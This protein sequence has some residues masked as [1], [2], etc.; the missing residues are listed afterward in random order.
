MSSQ[1]LIFT[2]FV[3]MILEHFEFSFY[4]MEYLRIWEYR[5]FRFI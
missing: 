3:L 2:V 5:I 4:D 1:Y